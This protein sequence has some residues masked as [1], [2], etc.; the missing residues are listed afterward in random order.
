MDIILFGTSLS[1]LCLFHLFYLLIFRKIKGKKRTVFIKISVAISNYILNI[2]IFVL[3][4]SLA[5][6]YASTGGDL[7][8]LIV[9]IVSFW[10][11]LT[12]VGYLFFY[13]I[14]S[15]QTKP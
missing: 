11:I 3:P 1:T 2:C 12:M 14:I 13:W 5:G 9:I 7:T 6:D 10:S 4:H 8:I 15:S